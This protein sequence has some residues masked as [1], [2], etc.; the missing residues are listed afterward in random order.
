[1]DWI[2]ARLFVD[3]DAKAAKAVGVR[4]ETVCRWPA[5]KDMDRVVR[6]FKKHQIPAART[7]LENAAAQAAHVMIS[8][9]R[10]KQKL[11][12]ANDVLDRTGVARLTKVAPTD[13]SGEREYDPGATIKSEIL[14][15]LSSISTAGTENDDN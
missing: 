7:M 14:S 1:M 13:P 12:A 9:L 15:A 2:L 8:E 10:G 4:P 11:K 5:K 3:S 6:Y